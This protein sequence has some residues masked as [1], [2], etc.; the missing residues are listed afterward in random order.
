[1]N[2]KLNELLNKYWEGNSSLEEE[3]LMRKLLLQEEGREQEKSFFLGLD[4]LSKA[5]AKAITPAPKSLDPWKNWLRYAAALAILFISSWVSYNSYQSYQE[6]K[7]YEE[8]MQAFMLIQDNLQKGTA[9]FEA[10]EDLKYLNTTHEMFNI[11]DPK[12]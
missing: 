1:M 6:R 5:S 4:K 7:A 2:D 12:Y 3:R 8:V 10:M 9:Q 11:D